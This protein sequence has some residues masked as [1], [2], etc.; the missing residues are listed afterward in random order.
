MQRA[1]LARKIQP[2]ETCKGEIVVWPAEIEF[3]NARTDGDVQQR[4][5]RRL[6][7]CEDGT[8]RRE[9]E[10]RDRLAPDFREPRQRLACGRIPCPDRVVRRRAGDYAAGA[11][12]PERHN[13]GIVSEETDIPAHCL[14]VRQSG[15][16]RQYV[17]MT[18]GIADGDALATGQSNRNT[19][20]RR[21]PQRVF[22]DLAI[23]LGDRWQLRCS[24]ES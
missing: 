1:A 23:S 17:H 3:G 14:D 6:Q 12:D 8:V 15:T 7:Y 18:V 5:A 4:N 21:L 16:V 24:P 13:F 22:A 2:I 10:L 20:G 19:I 11:I 9:R